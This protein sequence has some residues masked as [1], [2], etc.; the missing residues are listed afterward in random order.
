MSGGHLARTNSIKRSWLAALLRLDTEPAERRYCFEPLERRE[1]MAADLSAFVNGPSHQDNLA[2]SAFFS[3]TTS[4]VATSLVGEGEA[5]ADLVAFA[6]LLRD[7]GVT[8]FGSASNSDTSQQRRLFEDGSDFLEFIDVSLP[9]NAGRIPSGV[10]TL[11]TWEYR[12]TSNQPAL[13]SGIQTPQQLSAL[14]GIAIPM[15]SNPFLNAIPDASVQQNSPLHIPVDAY[16]PNGNPLTVTVTSSNSAAVTAEVVQGGRSAV[17]STNF[18]DMTVRL[19]EAE[20]PRPTSRFIALAQS[21]FYNTTNSQTRIIHRADDGFVIQGGSSDGLGSAGSTLGNFD[22]QLSVNLQHNRGGVLSYAKTSQ[23]DTND[24]QWFIT[25]QATPILNANHSVFGQLIEGE[26][27]REAISN[28]PVDGNDKPLTNVIINSVTI[29]DDLENGLLRLRTVGAVGTSSVITVTV[30][31][32]EG[33]QTSRTFTA[34]VVAKASNDAPFLNDFNDRVTSVGGQPVTVQLSSQDAEGDSVEYFVQ[35]PNGSPLVTTPSINP[36]TGLLTITPPAGFVGNFSVIAGVRAAGGGV[37]APIDT[38]TIVVTVNAGT[39]APTAVDLLAASD[40]GTSSTDNITNATSMT[41]AVAGTV[42]GANVELLVNGTVAASATATSTSTSITTPAISALGMGT[43]NVTARQT[44]AGNVSPASAPLVVTFDNVAP[45][46]L[47]TTAIPS[48]ARI[49]TPLTVNLN[50]PEEGTGLRYSVSSAPAGLQINATTGELTWTP[51]IAQLGPQSFVLSLT[52]AAGN[53]QMQTININV[54]EPALGSIT[55]KIVDLAGAEVTDVNIGQE[56]RLQVF[57]NDLRVDENDGVF[58]A[59][60]DLLYSSN[61]ITIVGTSPITYFG[62]FE[63]ALDGDFSTPGLINELGGSRITTEFPE[64]GPLLFAEVRFRATATGQATFTSEAADDVGSD[65]SLYSREGRV[66]TDRILYSSATVSVGRTFDAVDDSFNVSEG[67]T[68]NVLD[69]LLNDTIRPGNTTTLTLVRVEPVAGGTIQG[70]VSIINNRLVYTPPNPDFNGAEQFLYV[71]RDGNGTEATATVTI[72]VDDV[73]DPPI[74]V[75]DADN[76]DE[77]SANNFID[78]LANDTSGVDENEVLTVTAVGTPSAGG[79]VQIATGGT[80]VLYTPLAGFNGVETF[81]YTISDGRGGTATTSVTINVAPAVPPPTAVPDAFTVVEDA[82][83]AEFDVLFNDVPSITG[84]TLSISGATASNGGT[85]T[86]TSGG[87]RITYRP[88]AN[89]NGTEIVTYT[90]VGSNGGRTLGIATFTVTPV[91]DPPTANDDALTVLSQ[92]NQILDVLAN[93]TNV[94]SGEVL[95]ITSISGLAAGQ[96]TVT[97][98]ADGRSLIYNAPNTD[99]QGTVTFTYTLSDGTG[100]TDTANVTLTV[101]NFIPRAIGG[102]LVAS[103]GSTG[104]LLGLTVTVTGTA[105]TGEQISRTVATTADGRFSA[106]DLPPGNYTF[107]VPQLAFRTG[108]GTLLTV[109]SAFEDGDSLNN[110]LDVGTLQPRL[111]DVRDFLGATTGR[112]FTAALQVGGTQQWVSPG[113]AWR[114]YQ[115][116]TAALNATAT[117]ITLSV[118]TADNR[119]GT[120]T[121]DLSNTAQVRVRASEGSARYVHVLGEPADFNLPVPSG[122]Q[123]A[124]NVAS[125]SVGLTTASSLRTQSVVANGQS[126]STSLVDAAMQDLIDFSNLDGEQGSESPALSSL[127]VATLLR[128]TA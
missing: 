111:V 75:A 112:G 91:N 48:L 54:V 92:P 12:N 78:V 58:A 52:D 67:S 117:Q 25:E 105:V 90:L 76:V 33:N 96:G 30:T 104:G 3:S 27:V 65:F 5:A 21:G 40:S 95:T 87:Q 8:L 4:N 45:A 83:A 9:E 97:I 18:G 60:L 80:G 114:G 101:R 11:P 38:Q 88:A 124:S 125:N 23:D 77:S 110:V 121:I 49:G 22:D 109:Q 24:S 41:F 26:S 79:S 107:S 55:F 68:D 34:T 59:Y 13:V 7:G 47:A 63:L 20:A 10:T 127:D 14:T 81:T 50:H 118:T 89:F 119:T 37:T 120:A 113:G 128:P 99:F 51:V 126:D 85:V 115:T 6:T 100:L 36:T 15:A 32:T 43:A 66:P 53:A 31:D 102:Q 56:F 71:V 42:V 61:L 16:D 72:L 29:F 35:L 17:I 86:V 1:L 93:D 69:V 46:L 44:V 39:A 123:I 84:E 2:N 64:P 74:A 73:N 108:V 82:N 19:F 62:R 106:T 98:A 57:A 122:A 70:T 94:D 103:S 116:I 28:T